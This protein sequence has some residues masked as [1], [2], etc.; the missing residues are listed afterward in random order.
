MLER[1]SKQQLVDEYLMSGLSNTKKSHVAGIFSYVDKHFDKISLVNLVQI[2]FEVEILFS[3]SY[4]AYYCTKNSKCSLH[5]FV[6]YDLLN[7][8]LH[9]VR[10]K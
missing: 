1:K 6:L 4:L 8:N 9:E 3:I 5:T 10:N 7:P 2:V